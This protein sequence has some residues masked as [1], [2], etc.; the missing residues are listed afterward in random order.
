METLL[1]SAVDANMVHYFF[2]EIEIIYL[3]PA[4]IWNNAVF[5]ASTDLI[6]SVTVET[7]FWTIV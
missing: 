4:L 2:V 6:T 7:V 3:T 5:L 1:S